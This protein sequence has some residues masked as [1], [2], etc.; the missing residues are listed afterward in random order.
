MSEKYS[1]I[2]RRSWPA[3]RSRARQLRYWISHGTSPLRLYRHP[4]EE[5]FLQARPPARHLRST[6]WGG[7]AGL[8]SIGE[9]LL[10][11]R[12]KI[13]F[14][15]ARQTF[16]SAFRYRTARSCAPRVAAKSVGRS[17]GIRSRQWPK[18]LKSNRI[19]G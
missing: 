18:L 4:T 5:L 10:V 13:R 6:G 1:L 14:D 12:T 16:P 11:L 9:E 17:L 8:S 3:C 2:W 19:R 7:Y 15:R